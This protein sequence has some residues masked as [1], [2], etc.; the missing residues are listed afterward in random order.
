MGGGGRVSD[1][2]REEVLAAS[3]DARLADDMRAFYAG[4]DQAIATHAPVCTNRGACCNF[5]TFG[6]RM[7]VTAV[8]LAYFAR[9]A[10]GPVRRPDGSGAC[11]YQLDGQ[12]SAREH[13]P[14]GCRVFFCDEQARWWQNEEYERQLGRLKRIGKA[15]G[16]PYSYVEW[17]SALCDM[18]GAPN[19]A[20]ATS[21]DAATGG[22]GEFVDPRRLP[23]IES[24]KRR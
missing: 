20:P 1:D 22:G 24:A 10:G 23:V 13:R 19:A 2:L 3:R 15:H 14:L 17:L 8:E 18:A 16:V 7:Y 6:H 9:G 4:V 11:P 12:C 21:A 5:Q